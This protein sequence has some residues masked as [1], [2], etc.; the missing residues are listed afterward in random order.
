LNCKQN[1][2]IG[3]EPNGNFHERVCCI[4]SN[5]VKSEGEMADGKATIEDE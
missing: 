1:I 5:R 2:D 4:D 3:F